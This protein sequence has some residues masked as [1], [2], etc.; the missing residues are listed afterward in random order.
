[1]HGEP[2]EQ[3]ARPGVGGERHRLAVD[4]CGKPSEHA[5]LD[6]GRDDNARGARRPDPVRAAGRNRDGGRDGGGTAAVQD[7][8]M[9]AL[10]ASPTPASLPGTAALYDVVLAL[11]EHRA[12]R[13][14]R[15]ATL[16]AAGGRT[17][18]V[19]AGTGLNLPHYPAARHR[20]R[21]DGAGPGMARRLRRARPAPR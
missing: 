6:H 21:A 1:M 14:L 20:P 12:M 11:G 10:P 16:A 17:L 4:E 13:R 7:A 15:A 19:G 8:R 9:T 5:H 2:R 18:E 3:L